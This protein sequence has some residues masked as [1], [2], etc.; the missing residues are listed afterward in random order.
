MHFC[1]CCCF[2]FCFCFVL[3][4]SLT[5]VDGV[6]VIFIS[7]HFISFGVGVRSSSVVV[8]RGECLLW[9]H[10]AGSA[11]GVVMCG[12]TFVVFHLSSTHQK[13]AIKKGIKEERK[14]MNPIAGLFSLL[15]LA[16]ALG[17]ILTYCALASAKAEAG[18]P[19][20]KI[21]FSSSTTSA[22]A[23]IFASFSAAIAASAS[24]A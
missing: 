17:R 11:V 10:T 19:P 7:F 5:K 24:P 12:G 3:F 1:F 22:S 18:R 6:F 21:W 16:T 15:L 14:R 23:A 2:F 13:E 4:S 8:E 9:G 20:C